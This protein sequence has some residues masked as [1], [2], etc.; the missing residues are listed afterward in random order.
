MQIMLVIHHFRKIVMWQSSRRLSAL[1]DYNGISDL[2]DKVLAMMNLLLS[3]LVLAT[4][5]ILLLRS[6]IILNVECLANLLGA[7]AFD[8]VGNCLATNVE[9]GLDVKVVGSLEG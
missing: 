8:H 2:D 6:E 9:K 7:L 4:D 1:S 5:L 3:P